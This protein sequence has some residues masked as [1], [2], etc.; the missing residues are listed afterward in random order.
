MLY[1]KSAA[2]LNKFQRVQNSPARTATTSRRSD[3]ATPIF[4]YLHWLPIK[5]PG[6][7]LVSNKVQDGSHAITT[8]EP[9]LL[10]RL[11]RVCR[12]I[13]VMLAGVCSRRLSS[14]LLCNTPRRASLG[15]GP[16]EFRPIRAT[17]C[18][19]IGKPQQYLK[20]KVLNLFKSICLKMRRTLV[21]RVAAVKYRVKWTV[22][23]LCHTG[24]RL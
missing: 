23:M 12:T 9:L 3:H 8:Q 16:V 17:P 10:A 19:A 20:E 5:R 7:P 18:F 1:D 6:K 13:L 22:R 21:E 2:D 4:T 11:H 24:A 14:V 15:G